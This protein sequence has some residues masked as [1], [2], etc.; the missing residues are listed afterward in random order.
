MYSAGPG[1]VSGPLAGIRVVE[2]GGLGP[3]PFGAMM[4]ADLGADIVRIDRPGS[5]AIG[6]GDE[7]QD[8]LNRGR[9][10]VALDLRSPGE[11]A[12]AVEAVRVADVL[13]EGFRPGVMERLKLGPDQLM[14]TNPS[15]I[16]A[17]MTG[18]GQAGPM[19]NKAG[20]DIN[21]LS[22]T[23]GLELIGPF[24]GPP[25][26]P[27][28]YV[29]NFGGGGMLLA[30]GI[31]GALV[32]RATSGLGQIIDAAMVDG[33]SL[34]A[35]QVFAWTAMG[36]WQHGRGG[37]LL[38]GSAYFYRCY[39]TADGKFIAVGA[40]ESQ[41]H[42]ELVRGVGL[43]PKDFDDHLNPAHWPVRNGQF[44]DLFRTRT[45]DAWINHFAPF[46]ACISP[47]LSPEEAVAHPANTA[48]DVHV[49][50]NG[51][52]Q[53]APAPRFSRTSAATP[54]VPVRRGEGGRERL[55]AWGIDAGQSA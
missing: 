40:L 4:L 35:T 47:V 33:A 6:G 12:L 44:E 22:M 29:A 36:R 50:I 53:P 28:N 23:G 8:F 42:A 54:S 51:T 5:S 20:H 32:E 31:L 34:L 38:D 18:W 41:F 21:Y 2:F 43:E 25:V 27:I 37:N 10:S 46:D 49:S 13:I 26:P 39:E 11:H 14:S 9:P 3:T 52:M 48:R 30:V 7:R 55:G 1:N 15:L 45:R 17:R 19:A 16:Y 24:D